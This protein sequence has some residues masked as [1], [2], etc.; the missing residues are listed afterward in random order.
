MPK[1]HF[2]FVFSGMQEFEDDRT[3]E[4]LD[5]A[6]KENHVVGE[7]LMDHHLQGILAIF[8]VL[9]MDLDHVAI[10]NWRGD[11]ISIKGFE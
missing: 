9:E 4:E 10:L 6:V 8:R 3:F 5:M 11:R 1:Y 7:N 2:E